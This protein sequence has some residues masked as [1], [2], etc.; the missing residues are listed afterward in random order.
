[1]S[2]GFPVRTVDRLGRAA[3]GLALLVAAAAPGVTAAEPR[4][5]HD[6]VWIAPVMAPAPP[7]ARR[8]P[9]VLAESFGVDRICRL[10]ERSA[11]RHDLPPAY[12]ARLIWKESRFDVAAISPVGAQGIAQF[13]PGTARLEGLEDPF[14]PEQAI[15]ASARHLADLR[16]EFGNLGLAAAAY[17][18]GRNRVARWLNGASGLPWETLD[19]VNA[20][21]FRPADWFRERGREVEPRPLDEDRSFAEACRDLPVMKT[22]ALNVSAPAMKPWGVQL[23]GARTHDAAVRAFQRAV[24]RH[25]GVLGDAR[26]IV[27]KGRHGKGALYGARVGADSRAEAQKLCNRL[28]TAGGNCVVLKN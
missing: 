3:L 15:P 18:S 1:M 11:S 22:R 20:I 6:R 26:P 25:R 28:R 8:M 9:E 21:T 2:S 10:I 14:D 16:A 12:F 4:P 17:N 19:Y 23:A 5:P 13:M 27:L 7:P 24:A